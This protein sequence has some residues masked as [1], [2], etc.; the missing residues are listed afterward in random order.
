MLDI[1]VLYISEISKDSPCKKNYINFF[2]SEKNIYTEKFLNLF[3]Y[4]DNY[5]NLEYFNNKS[6]N[7]FN[8]PQYILDI[9][10]NSF[11]KKEIDNE[12]YSLYFY[13]ARDLDKL[14]NSI[15]QGNDFNIYELIISIET[16]C[17]NKPI[18]LQDRRFAYNLL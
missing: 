11:L 2:D 3:I 16:L 1:S 13:F 7:K 14:L 6:N 18:D 9:L 8:N 5:I 4:E 12:N 15:K 17:F 10:Q